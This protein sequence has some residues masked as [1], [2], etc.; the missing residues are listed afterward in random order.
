MSRPLESPLPSASA[1]TQ[2]PASEQALRWRRLLRHTCEHLG[3]AS[4]D[5]DRILEDQALQVGGIDLALHLNTP[6]G[7][8]EF[9]ADCGQPE[10]WQEADVCRSLLEEA[11]TCEIP[12]ITLALHPQSRHIVAKACLPLPVADED[13]WLCTAMLLATVTRA[14]EIRQRFALHSGGHS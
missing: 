6:V 5:A 11:L 9:Y 3:I 7:Q 13:G 1:D 14:R 10:P 4:Q 8:G 2:T 12:A